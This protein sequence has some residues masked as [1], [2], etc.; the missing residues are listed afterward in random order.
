MKTPS[1]FLLSQNFKHNNNNNNLEDE[2]WN[3]MF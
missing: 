2:G 1:P 3:K